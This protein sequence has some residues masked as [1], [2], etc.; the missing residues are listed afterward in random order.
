M[1]IVKIDDKEYDLES[2]SE[3]AKAIAA[4]LHAVNFEI[5][6]LQAQSAI[7]HT[8]RAAYIRSLKEEIENGDAPEPEKAKGTSD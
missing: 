2:L 6:R 8:A 3:K 1:A 4:H 7:Y 5:D